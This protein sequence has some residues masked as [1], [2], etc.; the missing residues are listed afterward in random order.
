[1]MKHNAF[2]YL[3]VLPDHA[4]KW[5]ESSSWLNYYPYGYF[6]LARSSKNIFCHYIREVSHG[7]KL[8]SA[9]INNVADTY[10]ILVVK[11]CMDIFT[12]PCCSRDYSQDI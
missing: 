2:Y 4:Y 3:A 11:T 10:V 9:H 12:F 7:K 1:M 5:V 8:W 6:I